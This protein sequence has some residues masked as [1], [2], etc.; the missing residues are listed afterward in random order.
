VE[1]RLFNVKGLR[2]YF[3]GSGSGDKFGFARIK[4]CGAFLRSNLIGGRSHLGVGDTWVIS[5]GVRG[6][7]ILIHER[8][9]EF[10]AHA[11]DGLLHFVRES[12]VVAARTNIF[13]VSVLSYDLVSGAFAHAERGRRLVSVHHVIVTLSTQ[14]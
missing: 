10:G 1:P 13:E 2:L 6:G 4:T 5:R 11:V 9:F 8:R 12:P 14:I 3:V 7:A